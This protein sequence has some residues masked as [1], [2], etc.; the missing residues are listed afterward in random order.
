[1]IMTNQQVV[2]NY[3][4]ELNHSSLQSNR[5]PLLSTFG[6]SSVVKLHTYVLKQILSAHF[7]QSAH[8]AVHT[9]MTIKLLSTLVCCIQI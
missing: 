6:V 4:C 2:V 9:T 1:M 3:Q 8:A 7:S 5:L